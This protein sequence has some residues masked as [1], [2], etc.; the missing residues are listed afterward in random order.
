M[1]IGPILI[2]VAST[3][4]SNQCRDHLQH[5]AVGG[6]V[7]F[8]RNY[9]DRAQL[10]NLLAEI[11]SCCD[12]R[13]LVTIDQEGG[14]VQRL[15]NSFTQLPPLAALGNLHEDDPHHAGDMAYRHGRVMATEMLACGIDVSFAPV[16]DL[17]RGS[18]VIGDRAL[19]D[20]PAVVIELAQ[21][22][23]AGMRDAGMKA[24]G[25]HFPGHGSVEA[26]S[27]FSDVRDIRP[28]AELKNNDMRPFCDLHTQL[29]AL[30]IAHVVYP[31]VDDRPAGYS[32]AWLRDI[33]RA[34]MGFQGVI[35]SD[36]LGMHAARSVGPLKHRVG[37]CIKAGCDL[38][39]VGKNE[40]VDPLLAEIKDNPWAAPGQPT[41]DVLGRLYGTASLNA[42]Q[43]EELKSSGVGEWAQWRRS[44]EGLN[45]PQS[46]AC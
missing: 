3:E 22:Y 39:L 8:S 17:G 20:D 14:R 11:Q 29:D 32:K 34:E 23:L 44:L 18:S 31:T 42:A 1:S 24:C 21:H 30:M 13:L 4:L 19:S 28:L 10:E 5:P 27:H 25:K 7:L 37:Q 6:V 2:G 40:D 9:R 46:S 41:Q 26:D 43:L 15:R 33:L 16:L 12:E 45:Q 36:D 35:I 38:V